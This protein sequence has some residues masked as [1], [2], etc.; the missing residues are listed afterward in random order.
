V[1]RR[2]F[3]HQARFC[4][5]LTNGLVE[6][7]SR[8]P[9][10]CS[11]GVQLSDISVALTRPGDV[12]APGGCGQSTLEWRARSGNRDGLIQAI[13]QAERDGRRAAAA[14]APTIENLAMLRRQLE[15]GCSVESILEFMV[16]TGGAEKRRAADEAIH[17]YEHAVTE[18][19]ALMMHALAAESG[20][21]VGEIAQQSRGVA[22]EA[23]QS[24]ELDRSVRAALEGQN[25]QR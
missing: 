18:L 15:M 13:E 8:T 24:S 20:V 21:R 9:Y 19:R 12:S 23:G 7:A 14:L 4:T 22:S 1:R 5:T 2:S 3:R 11:A 6:A 25:V 10:F 16:V 17:G